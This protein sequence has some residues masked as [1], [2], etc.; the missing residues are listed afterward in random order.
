MSLV[1]Q[2][3]SITQI[4]IGSHEHARLAGDVGTWMCGE[5]QNLILR[6]VLEYKSHGSGN[7]PRYQELHFGNKV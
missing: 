5:H 2:P 4:S 6:L 3:S 7:V 1:I